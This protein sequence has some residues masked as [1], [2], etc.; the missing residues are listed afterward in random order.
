[1]DHKADNPDDQARPGIARP[2]NRAGGDS[3]AETLAAVTSTGHAAVD[4]VADADSVFASARVEG[5]IQKR[6]ERRIRDGN[7]AVKRMRSG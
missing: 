3:Q 6:L 5:K 4:R 2:Q 1:M 7:P